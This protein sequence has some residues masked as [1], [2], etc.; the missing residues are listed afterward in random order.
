MTSRERYRF[1]SEVFFAAVLV[2]KAKST[3][4]RPADGHGSALMLR[5]SRKQLL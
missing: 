4:S 1:M 2:E 5:T 3:K